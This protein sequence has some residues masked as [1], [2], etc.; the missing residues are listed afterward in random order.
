MDIALVIENQ[1]R[2]IVEACRLA[3]FSKGR[4]RAKLI[5]DVVHLMRES[6]A[7]TEEAGVDLVLREL[8]PKTTVD[9]LQAERSKALKKCAKLERTSG[10][11]VEKKLENVEQC[12]SSLFAH[13]RALFPAMSRMVGASAEPPE[14]HRIR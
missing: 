11:R 5:T 8:F 14:T 12:L 7:A 4:Q 13:E 6:T 10:P 3:R 1:H 2:E 9:A